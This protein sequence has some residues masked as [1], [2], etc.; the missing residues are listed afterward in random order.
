MSYCNNS[1][2]KSSLTTLFVGVLSFF[3]ILS[4]LLLSAPHSF[5]DSSAALDIAVTVPAICSITT[6]PDSIS[7]TIAAGNS[8]TI[9]TSTIK[10]LCN[11]PGGLAIYAIGY[12]GSIHGDNNLRLQEAGGT[13]STTNLIPTAAA[14]SPSTSQWNM[15]VANNTSVQENYTATIPAEFQSTH[16][17]PTN[18]TIIA[19][20]PSTT[21][22]TTG[23]NINVT[24]S[25]Y[26]AAAQAA[27]TYK[28][29]VKY[30]LVH[31]SIHAA[32]ASRP[33]TLDIGQTVNVK[34]KSL[35]AGTT[36]T[37]TNN[38]S[39]IKAI[40]VHTG[41][42]AP[43]GFTPSE[44]NTI[45][46]SAS[47]QPIYIVFDNTNSAGVMHLYTMGDK[48]VLPADSSYMFYGL[49]SLSSAPGISSWDISKATNMSSMFA[50]AGRNA[51]TFTLDLSDWD[52]SNIT[53]MANM[54]TYAGYSATTWS[55]GDLSDWDTSKVTIMASM[56]ERAGYSATTWS[57][58]DLSDWDT[59]SV[60]DMAY[61]FAYAGYSATNW[62]IGDI[63]GWDVS[64][65]ENMSSMFS[66][67]GC[68]AST[69]S[70]NLSGWDTSS[71]TD[72][73]YM[74]Y[75]TG[76]YYASTFSLNLSGW[77]TSS[78]TDMY[79]MFVY[80]GYN[81]AATNWSVIIPQTNGN[82]ISNT[83]NYLYGKTT[84]TYGAPDSGKSFTLAQ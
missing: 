65:V 71:V 66:N 74:F 42:A 69:F 4:G 18:Q 36:K 19:S 46:S 23:V 81:T 59:S 13:L 22:Q 33:A 35:A 67:A 84:S 34:M 80:A 16:I 2:H 49:R 17:V 21:D 58:G 3:T 52:T 63:S 54:F 62:S 38:D 83:T 78:V 31:P 61:M 20:Y 48:I 12:T 64:K 8:G 24:Y 56:F 82:G 51:T 47:E 60:T 1:N 26:I 30:T 25:A 10:A 6:S 27:G 40:D 14:A 44:S 75:N 11:D 73:T 70:L 7:A 68:Y 79:Y 15:I 39:L 57:I 5:A 37:Y 50:Y 28:G 32:P 43:S 55:I 77:D 53:S 29:K 9:G 45:S 76:G 41:T 72:M